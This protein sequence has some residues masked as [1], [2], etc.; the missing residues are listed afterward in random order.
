MVLSD[1]LTLAGLGLAAVVVAHIGAYLLDP[2]NIRDIPGPTLA[3]FSDAWLGWVAAKG[4]RSEVV[5][6]MHAQY[7]PVVRIAPNHVS[8]AEPQALQI[9]YAHGNGSLKSNFYDAFVSIQRGL[10]NTRNRADHAR[11]RK[12]VSAIF[13]MKNVLE[14]EPHV[15]EY[16]GLLIKQWDRL[17][18][19][20]VKGGSGD[21]GEGGWR[22][23][24]GRLWL[25]CLPWYNYLAFDIIGDLAFGQSFGMLHACKDSAPVALSQDEAMKAYGSASGY[26]VVSIPAV[27]ILNDRGEFS[28]SIGV[29]PPAWRPFVKNLIPW[30][31]NGSKAV[32]NLA[33]LAVAAV[34]KR[35]DRDTLNGGSDRVDLLA[36]LQQGK[37]DEGKP[38]GREELTAEA[39]TQLIA[40]SDTTSN[41]SCAITYHLA[42]NPNVQAK[43][44]AELDEALGTDDDPVAIFDQV[45]RLTY[46][47]AVIDETLRIHSTS[48]IGL[49]RIVPAGSGGMHVAGH[50]F[51]E[52]T[53]LSVPTYTIHRDKEVWGEDVEVFR[54]ERFLEGD[55]AVIQKTFNPFSFGP[56][57]CV[58]RNLAN[59]EL[60]IIIASILRR[61][62][63]VL[64]HPEKPFDTR[65][66]FLRKPVECKV[67][68]KRRSA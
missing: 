68:I 26:K 35:L 41:S 37:D 1:P 23:E 34:A 39:L 24:S 43:L 52:G 51:P 62:H 27:Q 31:R 18:A 28:A 42:A 10:F 48:G 7:G 14:F 32:K 46:L 60:L 40:G 8:I 61:Y 5:H 29:L 64:E 17:C 25:D 13:S 44:H 19:E 65:E 66:G 33:G 50:F 2:H 59:M 21:E 6:E 9:V 47:Q 22:G 56:R 57:A 54:P 16:V 67:G 49:P 58:G 36:K 11:K 38:M 53:V 12:I 30:Y 55:Q 45:K 15:R 20:A 63:F 3:K 4:H